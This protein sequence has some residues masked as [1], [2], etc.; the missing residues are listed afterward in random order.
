M[1]RV[2]VKLNIESFLGP[3]GDRPRQTQCLELGTEC[4]KNSFL[5]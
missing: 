1:E 3:N 2:G 4:H 5:S